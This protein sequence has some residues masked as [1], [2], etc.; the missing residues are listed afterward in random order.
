VLL[1]HDE[2]F[3]SISSLVDKLKARGRKTKHLDS[4]LPRSAYFYMNNTID[5]RDGKKL[6]KKVENALK[7][8]KMT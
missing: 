8:E 7:D 3:P 5:L 1:L 4:K 2:A 6:N